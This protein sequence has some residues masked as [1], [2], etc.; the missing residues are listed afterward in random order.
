MIGD[1][2]EFLEQTKAFDKIIQDV[3]MVKQFS[4]TA[5]VTH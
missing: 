1:H 3:E 2:F 5:F 4:V